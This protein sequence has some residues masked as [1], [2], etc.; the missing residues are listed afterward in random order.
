MNMITLAL[1]FYWWQLKRICS[2]N[3]FN[4]AVM[5]NF[6]FLI[7]LGHPNYNSRAPNISLENVFGLFVHQKDLQKLHYLSFLSICRSL[8]KQ[9]FRWSQLF[10]TWQFP[11]TTVP[12][13]LLVKEQISLGKGWQRHMR[14]PLAYRKCKLLQVW[15]PRD[16]S[17]E[18]VTHSTLRPGPGNAMVRRVM[19]KRKPGIFRE[20]AKREGGLEKASVRG[21]KPL[22][23][24]KLSQQKQSPLRRC[25]S[26]FL[27]LHQGKAWQWCF[28]G[29]ISAGD[30]KAKSE[31]RL[32]LHFILE[33]TQS[34]AP[35]CHQYSPFL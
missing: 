29:D 12:Q 4:H 17:E 30:S 32:C 33:I 14:H 23:I 35:L 16:V 8:I 5:T 26:S 6:V 7:C 1:S 22:Q 24:E 18:K 10:T 3:L 20:K 11:L 19:E 2:H 34:S 21:S 27:L 25:I 9:T 15:E 28:L 13:I 31:I